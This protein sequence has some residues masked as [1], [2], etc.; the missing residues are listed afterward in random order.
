MIR[1]NIKNKLSKPDQN[2]IKNDYFKSLKNQH[3][4][5]FVV[6][7][8]FLSPEKLSFLAPK[9][10]SN[11]INKLPFFNSWVRFIL[12]NSSATR[13]NVKIGESEQN[14]QHP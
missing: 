12:S 3:N 14:N 10:C 7:V 8:I 11:P 6:K 2:V 1:V 9:Y 5:S 4:L 13:F